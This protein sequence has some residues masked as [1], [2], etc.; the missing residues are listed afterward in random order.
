MPAKPPGVAW[1]PRAY[2]G[3]SNQLGV[4]LVTD[5]YRSAAVSVVDVHLSKSLESIDNLP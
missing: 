3:Q 5:P 4:K 2:L 1:P